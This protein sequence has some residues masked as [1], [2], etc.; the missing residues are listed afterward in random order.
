MT[1]GQRILQTSVIHSQITRRAYT[2]RIILTDCS[3]R[4]LRLLSGPVTGRHLVSWEVFSRR[5]GTGWGG[6]GGG[7]VGGGG[8]GG[9]G[10]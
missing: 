7:G 4:V 9:G 3:G 10:K 1:K 2:V 8:G 5:D 6:G